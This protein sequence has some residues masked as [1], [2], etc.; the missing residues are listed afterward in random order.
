VLLD[1]YDTD[2]TLKASV[3]VR[4]DSIHVDYAGTSEQ[5]LH[6]ITAAPT[7]ATLIRSAR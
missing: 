3:I 6:S 7:T 2:V 4:E 5:V 1:G